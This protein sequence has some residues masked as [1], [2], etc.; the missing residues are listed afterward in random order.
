MSKIQVLVSTMDSDFYLHHRM[1]TLDSIIIN[2]TESISEEVV[3]KDHTVYYSYNEK[4]L[5]VSRNRALKH[6]DGEICIISDDDVKFVD[7]YQEKIIQA[8]KEHPQADV[9]AFQVSRSGGGRSKEFGSSFKRLNQLTIMRVS[10]VEITFKRESIIKNNIKFNTRF[11][12]GAKYRMGEENLFLSECIKK[13]LK[14]YYVPIKIGEVDMSTSSWFNGYATKYFEDK[15]AFFKAYSPY[16]WPLLNLQFLLRK[17][18]MLDN[19]VF[20]FIARLLIMTRGS[21]KYK[22]R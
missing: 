13:G 12:A 19:N 18:K 20:L 6:S 8:Y 1:N 9:I 3:R 14:I 21:I 2:Q 22:I 5:S 17:W 7:R 16:L 15:G 4:G 11:G 10:S